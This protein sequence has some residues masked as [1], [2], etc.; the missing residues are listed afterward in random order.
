MRGWI[1]AVA[2]GV[3]IGAGLGGIAVAASAPAGGPAVVLEDER[4]W[5]CATMGN[6]R[7]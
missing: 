6:R 1:A 2:L 4:G 5:G 7:C 3:L